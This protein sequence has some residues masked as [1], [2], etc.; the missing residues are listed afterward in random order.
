MNATALVAPGLRF[1]LQSMPEGEGCGG[2]NISFADLNHNDRPDFVYADGGIL[3]D[4]VTP[5]RLPGP[6]TSPIAADVNRDGHQDIVALEGYE[7][8]GLRVFLGDGRGNFISSLAAG[9]WNSDTEARNLVAADMNR[10]GR[11]DVLVTLS[12]WRTGIS[13]MRTYLGGGDGTFTLGVTTPL[14]QGTNALNVSDLDGDGRNDVLLT[15]A[16]DGVND[17][18]LQIF[19]GDGRGGFSRTVSQPTPAEHR[20]HGGRRSEPRRT[21]GCRWRDLGNPARHAGH[22]ERRAG[23][24]VVF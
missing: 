17:R 11:V 1:T 9:T 7:V 12:D 2:A 3:L 18:L 5:I 16:R 8:R 4:G 6:A 22:R 21:A 24:G 23:P 14:A 20:R 13:V 19:F 15:M 10:D